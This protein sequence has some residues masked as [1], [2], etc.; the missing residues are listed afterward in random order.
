MTKIQQLIVC[1]SGTG[2]CVVSHALDDAYM[3]TYKCEK[4]GQFCEI[5]LH[6]FH[7]SAVCVQELLILYG[8]LGMCNF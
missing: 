3:S 2:P 8:I 1:N 6:S 5:S 4:N 7:L